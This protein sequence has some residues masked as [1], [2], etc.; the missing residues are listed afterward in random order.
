[1]PY[2]LIQLFCS[3]HS[4]SNYPFV[5]WHY[6]EYSR[7]VLTWLAVSL[8]SDV[9]VIQLKVPLETK[10]QEILRFL[11]KRWSIIL[12]RWKRWKGASTRGHDVFHEI[13]CWCRCKETVS[14][15]T[16]LFLVRCHSHRCP[17]VWCSLGQL[18]TALLFFAKRRT[19]SKAC[20]IT[21]PPAELD[22]S[23]GLSL[24]F[25]Y[26]FFLY[27]SKVIAGAGRAPLWRLSP[28]DVLVHAVDL[29][30]C[31]ADDDHLWLSP[32]CAFSL[33]MTSCCEFWGPHEGNESEPSPWLFDLPGNGRVTSSQ[34]HRSTLR[35]KWHNFTFSL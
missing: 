14:C 22:A 4:N 25:I 32:L 33:F 9:Q 20:H 6:N 5:L 35:Q 7:S 12:L 24:F 29:A 16:D 31:G 3:V 27:N 13:F 15:S 26:L 18:A 1:M 23:K 2:P 21:S 34:K 10:P 28:F 17:P 11:E 8:A 19:L 30:G